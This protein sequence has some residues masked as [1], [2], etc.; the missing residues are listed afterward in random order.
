MYKQGAKEAGKLSSVKTEWL[1]IKV[2]VGMDGPRSS[3]QVPLFCVSLKRTPPGN[4]AEEGLKEPQDVE[5][6]LN[7]LSSGHNIM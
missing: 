2:T 5:E 6:Y 4:I 1:V 3:F 7:P